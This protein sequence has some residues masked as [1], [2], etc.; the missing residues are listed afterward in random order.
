[1]KN[2]VMT[3]LFNASRSPRNVL[4]AF[5]KEST[6]AV[7]MING[8][9]P[10]AVYDRLRQQLPYRETRTYLE[11]VTTLRKTFVSAGSPSN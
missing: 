3:T 10:A 2:A 5:S 4:R 9:Q 8:L 1:V 6:A 7:N 11:R